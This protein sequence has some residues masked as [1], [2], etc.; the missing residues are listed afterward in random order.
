[1]EACRLHTGNM[2]RIN[3]KRPTLELSHVPTQLPTG[4]TL[5]VSPVRNQNRTSTWLPDNVSLATVPTFTPRKIEIASIRMA[6]V[7]FRA[8]LSR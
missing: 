5:T 1:M 7:V 8:A 6:T 3:T 4:M 2:L